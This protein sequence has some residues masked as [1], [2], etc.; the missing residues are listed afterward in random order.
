MNSTELMDSLLRYTQQN[1]LEISGVI[2]GF[3]CVYLNARENIWGWPMAILSCF[4]YIFIMHQSRFYADMGLQ[5]VYV[6]L[7]GFGWYQWLYG[8]KNRQQREVSRVR[9]PELGILVLLSLFATGAMFA[10]FSRYTDAA[11][12][13]W[14]SFN[15][16]FSLAALYLMA[17]KRLENWL[18]WIMVDIIYV[19]LFLSREL[20]LTTG[21]YLAYLVLAVFGYSEWRKSLIRNQQR[22]AAVQNA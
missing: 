1:W 4:L 16:A 14:D 5:I 15:T 11:Q 13:F 17:K 7:N 9:W 10:Y 6:V 12:P 8:G 22:A 19:P 18:I 2:T 3:V 21:L 20:Y